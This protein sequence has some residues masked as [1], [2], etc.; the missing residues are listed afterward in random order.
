MLKNT[1]TPFLV[2]TCCVFARGDSIIPRIQWLDSVRFT[3]LSSG[4]LQSMPDG[5]EASVFGQSLVFAAARD[6][7]VLN[8]GTF[9]IDNQFSFR[10]LD[11]PYMW[12]GVAVGDLYAPATFGFYGGCPG[13]GPIAS[14]GPALTITLAAGQCGTL[15]GYFGAWN[16]NLGTGTIILTMTDPAGVPEPRYTAALIVLALAVACSFRPMLNSNE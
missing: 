8:G 14:S 9:Q 13:P 7:Y 3:S 16:A 2:F 5:F 11:D 10:G 15:T 6:F 4:S 1:V 12:G